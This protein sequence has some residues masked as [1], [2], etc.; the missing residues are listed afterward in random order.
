MGHQQWV[1]LSP[2]ALG[3]LLHCREGGCPSPLRTTHGHAPLPKAGRPPLKMLLRRTL[4]TR[5]WPW[6]A[7]V[8]PTGSHA[9]SGAGKNNSTLLFIMV[10][11]REQM[12]NNPSV[13]AWEASSGGLWCLHPACGAQAARARA[14][15]GS[16]L[17]RWKPG[18]AASGTFIWSWRWI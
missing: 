11:S 4:R 6:S 16:G 8:L 12:A 17:G 13:L 15:T 1:M 2:R 5:L 18:P 14:R 10:G 3:R 9:S 7:K